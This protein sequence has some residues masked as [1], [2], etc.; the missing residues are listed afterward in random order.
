MSLEEIGLQHA[1]TLNVSKPINLPASALIQQA[2][3]RQEG[4]LSQTGSLVVRTGKHTGRS[5]KDKWIVCDENTQ[6][7]IWWSP[8]GQG[9][10]QP[11]PPQTFDILYKE[12]SVFLDKAN[13][14]VQDCTVG[15]PQEG[16]GLRVRVITQRAW[17]SLFARN[18]FHPVSP[19][20][21]LC[22]EPDFVVLHAPSFHADP[23]VHN[24]RS[25][26]AVI[27][28]FSRKA[29]VICGTEFAGEIKK[30]VFTILN[31]VLLYKET[32]GMHCA[33][34]TGLHGDV[35]LLFG[36][37][38][39]GKTTLSADPKRQLIGDDE[40]GWSPQGI[41][42]FEG[43][44]YAKTIRLH[45]SHE[46]QIFSA[47]QRPG[48][49]LENVVLRN[50][51]PDFADNSLTENTRA[52]YD[53]QAIDAIVSTQQANHPSNV[54][55]LTCDA[56]GVLPPLSRLSPQ[57]AMYHFLSGYTSKIPGTEQ[58]ICQPKAVFSPCYAAPFL[59]QHPRVYAQLF[60]KRVTQ[61]GVHC[62]LLNTGWTGGSYGVGKRIPIALTR[63]LLHCALSGTLN[64]APCHVY[65]PFGFTIPQ[66]VPQ[67]PT[68][69]L[70][71]QQ[72][73]EDNACY[74][75]TLRQLVHMFANNMQTLG[76][77]V[78]QDVLCAGPQ[79]S[80]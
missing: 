61:H 52:S 26:T 54:V 35:A 68:H 14:Y 29:V 27:I 28:D 58:G 50:G 5:P 37:S 41:F 42:N 16:L 75:S 38:G 10:N 80:L 53:L 44:C 21:T 45:Q 47:C 67:I 33:A 76:S 7:S 46:P 62:W 43:G 12:V 39:T 15:R 34:T 24:T 56:F 57:Q 73:W 72:A 17:H 6:N 8:S 23:R 77:Q 18:M 9:G 22:F 51:I 74:Q 63:Q 59:P 78:P 48:A 60:G 36:L 32:L 55:L 79:A 13:A 11:Y 40:H 20:E 30:S 19:E 2:V 1:Q 3:S 65:K 31:H 64:D 66:H 4:T 49:I 70:H 25:E 71:P 69:L